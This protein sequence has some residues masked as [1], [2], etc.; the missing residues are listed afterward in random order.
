MLTK[1]LNSKELAKDIIRLLPELLQE[2][3]ELKIPLY[4]AFTEALYKG[5]LGRLQQELADFQTDTN[6]NFQHVNERLDYW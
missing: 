4:K 2:Q 3:P 5:E 1:T 6:N